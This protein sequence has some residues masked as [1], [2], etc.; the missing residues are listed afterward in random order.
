[1]TALNVLSTIHPDPLDAFQ[2]GVFENLF[3]ARYLSISN[4]CALTF[5]AEAIDS[6]AEHVGRLDHALT[7]AHLKLDHFNIIM[8]HYLDTSRSSLFSGLMEGL[9]EAIYALPVLGPILSGSMKFGT[10]LYL[11]RNDDVNSPRLNESLLRL[12]FSRGDMI[13]ESVSHEIISSQEVFSEA[14]YARKLRDVLSTLEAEEMLISNLKCMNYFIHCFGVERDPEILILIIPLARNASMQTCSIYFDSRTKAM[15][16][17]WSTTEITNFD[18]GIALRCASSHIKVK[19]LTSLLGQA[20][21]K[22]Y[23]RH[24]TTSSSY[25]YRITRMRMNFNNIVRQLTPIDRRRALCS[26]LQLGLQ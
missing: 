18:M 5:T 26:Y 2:L 20:E 16:Y 4:F 10:K 14:V 13:H 23:L 25:F 7:H 3:L 11:W 22:G 12:R 17:V 1:M 9:S 21:F 15:D 6:L 8:N 19:G 24:K